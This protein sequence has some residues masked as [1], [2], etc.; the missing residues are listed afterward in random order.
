[1]LHYIKSDY[2]TSSTGIRSVLENMS[3]FKKK[4]GY[5]LEDGKQL[6]ELKKKHPD[7]YDKKLETMKNKEVKASTI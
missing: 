7:K 5:T 3:G 2:E 4:Y 6:V 1:M